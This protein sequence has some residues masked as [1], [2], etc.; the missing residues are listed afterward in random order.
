MAQLMIEGEDDFLFVSDFG[1]KT[2]RQVMLPARD[3]QRAKYVI[4]M[5]LEILNILVLR[6]TIVVS[7]FLAMAEYSFP[8]TRESFKFWKSMHQ[9]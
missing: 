9:R 4:L 3:E 1:R 8:L 5:N 2:F 6:C 7:R